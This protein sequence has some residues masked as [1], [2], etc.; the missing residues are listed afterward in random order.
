MIISIFLGDLNVKSYG[1]R[2]EISD[3]LFVMTSKSIQN[4]SQIIQSIGEQWAK[5]SGFQKFVIQRLNFPSA[6]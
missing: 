1:F 3:Q 2:G 4:D 5:K 6:E